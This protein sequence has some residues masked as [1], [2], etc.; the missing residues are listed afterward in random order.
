MNAPI[1]LGKNSQIPPT[2][3]ELRTS[4]SYLAFIPVQFSGDLSRYHKT[5]SVSFVQSVLEE[6]GD[7]EII[8]DIRVHRAI[9]KSQFED[10]RNS[11]KTSKLRSFDEE[12]RKNSIELGKW[13][14]VRYIVLMRV[15][16]S[17]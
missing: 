8:D 2:E 5:L 4:K 6:H 16:T 12:L 13:L 1:D 10:L 15:Q 3:E 7:L 14:R 11:L 17:P 9:N